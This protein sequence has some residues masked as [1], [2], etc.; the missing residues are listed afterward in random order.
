MRP[1]A[2][3]K[4]EWGQHDRIDVASPIVRELGAG[5]PL[6]LTTHNSG[7]ICLTC[8]TLAEK[9]KRGRKKGNCSER[10]RRTRTKRKRKYTRSVYCLSPLTQFRS[11]LRYC[12]LRVS[13]ATWKTA[14]FPPGTSYREPANTPTPKSCARG[15]QTAEEKTKMVRTR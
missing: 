4:S 11:L 5:P 9:R 12:P 6:L 1:A 13:K 2:N 15:L 10:E 3:Q 14:L 7:G 8:H